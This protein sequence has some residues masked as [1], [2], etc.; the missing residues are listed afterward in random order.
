MISSSY[1]SGNGGSS[2][3]LVALQAEIKNARYN[4][5]INKT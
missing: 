3:E 5:N 4:K 1:G 2:K